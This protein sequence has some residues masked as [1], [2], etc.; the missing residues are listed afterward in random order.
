MAKTVVGLYDHLVQ[1]QAATRDLVDAGIARD[2][3]SLVAN[4][5]ADD[6]RPYFDE[7]GRYREP[8]P[9]AAEATSEA[10]EGA[11][12]GAGIGA[13][14]GGI[15]GLLMGLGL[16]AIPGVGP[17]L[18]AGPIASALVGAGIG[19]AAGGLLGALVGSGVPEEEAG[20]YAE[21]VRRGGS[22]VTVT[23]DEARVGEVEAIMNRHQPVDIDERV[24]R[25]RSEGFE[26]YD[27]NAEPY[28]PEEIAAERE[29]F[30]VTY[31]PPGYQSG[32][33]SERDMASAY[34]QHFDTTYAD[35]GHSYDDYDPAYAYG[36]QLACERGYER[37]WSE[38]EPEVRRDWETS[39]PG[40][41]DRYRDAIRY[42]YEQGR[43]SRA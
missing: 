40:T 42:S 27:P 25:W 2:N 37:G 30:G 14:L 38:I 1:A 15:G 8:D 28:R 20:Y 23:V 18:A 11:A 7:E 43:G 19:A 35:L 33:P 17:A 41:W 29:R 22:L 13:T 9:V 5:S 24:T 6:Y 26:S 32:K 21:G 34:R 16:L 4:A 3:I 39:S 12:T 10:G 36:E 31:T